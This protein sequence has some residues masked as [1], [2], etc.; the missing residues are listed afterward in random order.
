MEA[1]SDSM[2]LIDGR[3]CLRD[4]LDLLERLLILT[5]AD[6]TASPI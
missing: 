2:D 1:T 6:S 5:V 3:A 4:I